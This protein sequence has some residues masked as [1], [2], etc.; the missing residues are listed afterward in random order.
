MKHLPLGKLSVD[1]A[2]VV[3]GNYLRDDRML[4]ALGLQHYPAP[5]FFRPARPATCAINWKARS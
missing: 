5:F 4:N 3:V 1:H 2:F